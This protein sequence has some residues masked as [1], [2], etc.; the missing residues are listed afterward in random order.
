MHPKGYNTQKDNFMKNC[1][2]SLN[3][4]LDLIA[5]I[6]PDSINLEVGSQQEYDIEKM[7]NLYDR[8]RLDSTPIEQKLKEPHSDLWKVVAYTDLIEH[9]VNMY[10]DQIE[11]K[12]LLSY[13][14]LILYLVI[15]SVLIYLLGKRFLIPISGKP[16]FIHRLLVSEKINSLLLSV[17]LLVLFFIM[18]YFASPFGRFTSIFPFN[19]LD[20]TNLSNMIR[21][22]FSMMLQLIALYLL[23]LY[24][25]VLNKLIYKFFH[26][27]MQILLVGLVL[28]TI[29]LLIRYLDIYSLTYDSL[30]AAWGISFF[31]KIPNLSLDKMIASISILIID[32]AAFVG[33]IYLLVKFLIPSKSVSRQTNLL[34]FY[35][36]AFVIVLILIMLNI[37][38]IST[39]FNLLTYYKLTNTRKIVSSG[40]KIQATV[41]Q[42]YQQQLDRGFDTSEIPDSFFVSVEDLE[43]T[44]FEKTWE[45]A[46]LIMTFNFSDYL[47]KISEVKQYLQAETGKFNTNFPN[48]KYGWFLKN[49]FVIDNEK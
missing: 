46:K 35:P 7:K 47:G 28:G 43:N 26:K 34:R 24:F 22:G 39:E 4:D 13:L 2:V 42:W 25:F 36:L 17:I 3:E 12:D 48:E 49:M 31:Y 33:L 14:N 18:Q 40:M 6:S 44:E 9:R 23:Y 41:Y 19:Q 11:K 37:Q 1:S 16:D 5:V 29:I 15:G 30:Q 20:F 45:N 8:F 21:F 32:V 27:L 38:I 10:S